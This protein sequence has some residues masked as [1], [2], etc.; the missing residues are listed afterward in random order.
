MK[1]VVSN[2]GTYV[3]A[4]SVEVNGKIFFEQGSI[5]L[6]TEEEFSQWLETTPSSHRREILIEGTDFRPY[7]VTPYMVAIVEDQWRDFYH[8]GS[9]PRIDNL[10]SWFVGAVRIKIKKYYLQNWISKVQDEG[11]M[12]FMDEDLPLIKEEIFSGT[13]NN[14]RVA[15]DYV[16]YEIVVVGDKGVWRVFKINQSNNTIIISTPTLNDIEED[17]EFMLE[18]HKVNITL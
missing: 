2:N 10:P 9:I 18:R 3:E 11:K 14:V 7:L 13:Y 1:K 15:N 6:L 17:K 12:F 8:D 5:D 4:K 16:G